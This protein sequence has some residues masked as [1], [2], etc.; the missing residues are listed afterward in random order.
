MC[1][2]FEYVGIGLVAR[3]LGQHRY[4]CEWNFGD[5]CSCGHGVWRRITGSPPAQTAGATLTCTATTRASAC[6]RHATAAA[7]YRCAY[8]VENMVLVFGVQSPIGALAGFTRRS[9]F[10]PKGLVE[11]KIVADR[12]LKEQKDKRKVHLHVVLLC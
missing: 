11:R 4:G 9:W 6:A 3:S 2:D 8:F 12:I 1:F 7:W 5:G 10:A